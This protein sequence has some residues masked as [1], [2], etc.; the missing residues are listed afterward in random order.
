M[1]THKVKSHPKPFSQVWDGSKR[2][3]VRINDRG[4]EQGDGIILEEFNPHTNQFSGRT[5]E[6]VVGNVTQG[7]NFGLP[8]DIC[9]FTLLHVT[10][11]ENG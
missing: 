4:Y 11:Q 7:G 5:I 3:E 1:K 2:H 9:C 10:P 6:A 8:S